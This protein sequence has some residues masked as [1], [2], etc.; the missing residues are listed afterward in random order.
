MRSTSDRPSAWISSADRLVVVLDWSRGGVD[1]VAVGDAPDAGVVARLRP[2]VLEQR[3]HRL[4]AR[5][6][7]AGDEFFGTLDVRLALICREGLDFLELRRQRRDQWILRGTVGDERAHADQG[8]VDHEIRRDHAGRTVIL[9]PHLRLA[10][11]ASE[12]GEARQV[13]LDAA[14][15]LDDVGVGQ[16]LR[17]ADRDAGNLV[18]AVAA[19]LELALADQVVEEPRRGL[20][21]NEFLAREAVRTVLIETGAR[22]PQ[23][24]Q[25]FVFVRLGLVIELAAVEVEWRVVDEAELGE[26]LRRVG[27]QLQGDLVDVVVQPDGREP[28]P[29]RCHGQA[30]NEQATDPC[31]H[32]PDFSHRHPAL[33]Q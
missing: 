7:F 13:P 20:P 28:E 22:L 12:L 23:P 21:G 15:V 24:G 19:V 33:S 10:Q 30:D 8:L 14:L 1:A 18:D 26:D 32:L 9:D 2:H 4:V 17:S 27:G 6:H 3:D 29:H 25:N 11:D 31:Q 5:D 16:E